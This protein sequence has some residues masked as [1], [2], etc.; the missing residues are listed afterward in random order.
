MKDNRPKYF[1]YLLRSSIIPEETFVGFTTDP[2]QRIKDHNAGIAPHTSKFRP[3]MLI[4][5][6]AF[7]TKKGALEFEN[8]LKSHSGK[9]FA[10]RDLQAFAQCHLALDQ[11][12]A[13]FRDSK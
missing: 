3:W 4:T 6:V 13:H 5:Y 1:V 7:S 8:Y 12:Y 10:K 11:Y 9:A 2:E